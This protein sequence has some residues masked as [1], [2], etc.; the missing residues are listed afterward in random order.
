MSPPGESRAHALPYDCHLYKERHLVELFIDKIKHFRRIATRY[1]RLA[2]DGVSGDLS[3]E[4]SELDYR[5]PYSIHSLA[6]TFKSASND[7]NTDSEAKWRHLC[8]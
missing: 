5:L 1:D 8:S 3:R 4:K 2:R 6:K 7:A